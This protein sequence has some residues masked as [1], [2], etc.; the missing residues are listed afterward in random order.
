MHRGEERDQPHDAEG[1]GDG[2]TTDH[3]RQAGGDHTAEDEEQ[4]DS[5]DR[6]R[7][8][9]HALLVLA[10]GSGQLAGHGL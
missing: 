8:H 6:Q 5:H 4:H 7:Q 9:L 10:D 3:Q 2:K 1:A